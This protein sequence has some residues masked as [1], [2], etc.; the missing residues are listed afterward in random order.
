MGVLPV[1]CVSVYHMHAV[2]TIQKIVWNCGSDSGELPCGCWDLSLAF[3]KNSQFLMLSH[4]YSPVG[5]LKYN[6]QNWELHICII[7]V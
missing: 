3:W 5:Y 2:P 4:L 7:L 6:Y 1:C